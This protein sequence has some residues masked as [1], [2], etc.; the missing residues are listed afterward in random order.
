[1]EGKLKREETQHWGGA[2]GQHGEH[3][4]QH[5]GGGGDAGGHAVHGDQEKH[6]AE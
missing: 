2:P 3:G 5:H 1:M 6:C 4:G